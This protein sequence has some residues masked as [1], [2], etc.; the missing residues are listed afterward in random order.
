MLGVTLACR[1]FQSL[2][3]VHGRV[4]DCVELDL[5]PEEPLRR[6]LLAY[7]KWTLKDAGL[8]RTPHIPVVAIGTAVVDESVASVVGRV[9]EQLHELGR[10]YRRLF[11]SHRDWRGRQHFKR[12]LP[13]LYGIVITYTVVSFVTYDSRFPGKQVQSMGCYD[14]SQKGGTVWLGLAVSLYLIK[15]RNYLIELEDAGF[16]GRKVVDDS[17][18]DA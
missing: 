5:T 11:Y 16:W 15:A 4:R 6:E 9:T 10:Q 14:Y 3:N 7:H 17:D 1:A 8:Y 2:L 12:E 13:T 18:P